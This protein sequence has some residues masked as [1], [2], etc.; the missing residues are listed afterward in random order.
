M[1]NRSA[2][3]LVE[4]LV[5]IAI[6]AILI[7]LLVPAIQ[8][9][10][11]S[12]RRT[13]CTSNMRQLAA[14]NSGYEQRKGRY[15]GAYEK[16]ADPQGGPDLLFTWAVILLPDLE[17]ISM[18][19]EYIIGVTPDVGLP[20][21]RCPSDSTIRDTDAECSY[22]A[23]HGVHGTCWE[24]LPS[25]GPFLNR[26]AH[27]WQQ[28]TSL[29]IRDGLDTTL[30]FSENIQ[31][32]KYDELGWSGFDDDGQID[33]SLLA[34]QNDLKWN[35]VFQWFANENPPFGAR[36]NEDKDNEDLNTPEEKAIHARPSSDHPGGVIFTFASGRTTFVRETI[37][38][39]VYQQLCTPDA[40]NSVM[41]RKD[42]ILTGT[43]FDY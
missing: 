7:A 31:A 13:N 25:N 4:L 43:D 9:I 36:I 21:Y 5:V 20:I 30:F 34:E 29:D 2:F 16:M 15:P 11:E 40:E 38:Y 28:T 37:D 23:N 12:A 41:P 33:P 1:K 26:A 39:V 24:D 17:Q 27:P 18:W 6:I 42:Y 10:R 19:N 22:V 14:A 8:F 3:T 35:P 32:T